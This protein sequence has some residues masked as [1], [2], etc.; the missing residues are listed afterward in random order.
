MAREHVD[1][2]IVGAGLSGIGAGYYVQTLCPTKSYLILEARQS[3]GGTW[4]LFRYP[5]IRSDSDMYTLGYTFHPW[6]NPKAIADGPSILDYIKET[7]ATYGIDQRIRYGHRV[8]ATAWSSQDRLWT[9]NVDRGPDQEPAQF[10]CSFLYTCTGYYD[11]ENGYTPDWP[12][13]EQFTGQIV[14]PQKWPADLEYAGKRVI[15]IGSG[16]T[17]V[18]LV[19]A[20][21]EQ[22]AHV[23]ML[24]RSP[25]YIVSLPAEDKLANWMRDHLPK[26]VAY[27]ITRWKIILLNMFFY[28][29]SRWRPKAIKRQI[30]KWTREALGP[31]F[32]V[33]T[34]FTPDYNPWD[35]RLC[36]V[37]DGDLFNA[38]KSG[39]VTVVTDHIE[40][41]TDRGLR[42]RSGAELEADIIVTA[43][44]LVMKLMKGVA[45]TVDGRPIHFGD[46]MAYKGMMVNDVPNTASAFGYT[47]A[48]WTLKCELT[49]KYV[50]RLINYMDKHGYRQCTPRQ[51][52]PS[53]EREPIVNFNS[54]YVL[55]ALPD[56]PHQGSKRPWKLYQNYLFDLLTLR[57]G[58]VNDGWMEFA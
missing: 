8:C 10:T 33:D 40:A 34:H 22:A 43:T 6:S 1:I 11:Y 50:C 57:Y 3:M 54:G 4:D 45:V 53:L 29:M 9:V 42:L 37:P 24:Q 49:S 32:D 48:S 5:G 38:I 17:A 36:L 19:P 16:A 18:T 2:L 56:L 20:L 41:F 46:R 39:K 31:D 47:N 58:A 14:H 12:G 52:D 7:A 15:V 51:H 28:Y 25:S 26:R 44:G 27:T 35:Q 30:V 23:T 21:A 55:R 13:M